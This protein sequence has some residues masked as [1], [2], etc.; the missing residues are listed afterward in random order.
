MSHFFSS[1]FNLSQ[2]LSIFFMFVLFALFALLFWLKRREM[3]FSNR[4]F[5]A[6]F[7]GIS[8]GFLLQFLAGFPSGKFA[9][10]AKNPELVFLH[11]LGIWYGFLVSV[12]VSFLKL[13][14]LPIVFFGISASILRLGRDI[15]ISSLLGRASFWLLFTTAI[16]SLIGFSLG[17]MFDLGQL[18]AQ[19]SER[20]LRAGRSLSEILLGLIPS[21]SIDAMA[22]N[23]LV[24]VI[25]I[26]L[27]IMLAARAVGSNKDYE[28]PFL[29]FKSL[30]EL[31]NR[32]V[33]HAVAFILEF[34]PYAVIAMMANTLIKNG[35]SAMKDA[36]LFIALIY[37]AGLLMFLVY[38]AILA[39]Y[40]ISPWRF[41]K[42]AAPTLIAAFSSRS[43]AGTLPMTITS[44]QKIG[45]SASSSNFVAT[46]GATIGMNGCAGYFVGLVGVFLLNVMG[47]TID[48]SHVILVVIITL[49]GGL[50]IA[51]VPGIA[52]VAASIMATGL[53]AGEYFYAL[54]AVLAID[55]I[56][57][58]MRTMS[59]VCGAM[60]SAAAT[61]KALGTFNDE[62]LN[63]YKEEDMDEMA[64]ASEL[65]TAADEAKKTKAAMKAAALAIDETLGAK[66]EEEVFA[67][68]IEADDTAASCGLAPPG[69]VKSS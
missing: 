10:F 14:I 35:P 43:S 65:A 2:P 32:A 1:F 52:I 45:V 24:G 29:L 13:M 60:V 57:D 36:A 16:A 26:T 11:E 55:P 49:V 68:G 42:V 37:A 41:F 56:V 64:N 33:M 17:Y 34:M 6:L 25:I 67:C 53:G 27:I 62:A 30:L 21:N 15:K 3:S 28:K 39:V 5:L 31:I 59:N 48:A 40:G 22:K 23:N 38:F 46:L 18:F 4:M 47:V 61:D 12:F 44:L 63:Q 9:T 66:P 54:G 19:S 58:M 51:G 8:L 7:L 20:E 50:S 69:G